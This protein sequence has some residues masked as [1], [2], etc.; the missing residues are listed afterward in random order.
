MPRLTLSEAR[1]L[2]QNAIPEKWQNSKLEK[3]MFDWPIGKR[4]IYHSN[5][6]AFYSIADELQTVDEQQYLELQAELLQRG[7]PR[8]ALGRSRTSGRFSVPSPSLTPAPVI[9]EDIE[10]TIKTVMNTIHPYVVRQE[11]ILRCAFIG[12]LPERIRQRIG[13][14]C[15]AKN[16]SIGKPGVL[17]GDTTTLNAR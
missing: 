4:T 12:H 16:R 9:R 3:V 5:P 13:T 2:W 1:N 17:E 6:P 8:S 14:L 7:E 15:F 11:Q 10:D